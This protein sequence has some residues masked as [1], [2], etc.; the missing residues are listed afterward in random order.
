MSMSISIVTFATN[1]LPSASEIAN[2]WV[3]NGIIALDSNISDVLKR[4]DAASMYVGIVK[5]YRGRNAIEDILAQS[6]KDCSFVDITTTNANSKWIKESCQLGVFRWVD[7][8]FLDQNNLTPSQALVTLMRVLWGKQD[9]STTPW[10]KNYLDLATKHNIV[11]TTDLDMITNGSS[12][13]KSKIL[14]WIYTA[15]NSPTLKTDPLVKNAGVDMFG[16]ND[17]QGTT[18]DNTTVSTWWTTTVVENTR[19]IAK[20]TYKV[21]NN[22]QNDTINKDGDHRSMVRDGRDKDQDHLNK[23]WWWKWGLNIW[24]ILL[25]IIWLRLVWRALKWLYCSCNNSNSTCNLCCGIKDGSCNCKNTAS[26]TISTTTNETH[27]KTNEWVSMN[28]IETWW[29]TDKKEHVWK[30]AYQQHDDLKIIEGIWPK[31]EELLFENNITTF[32]QLA[33]MSAEEISS[34]LI[35]YWGNF[36]SMNT[37]TWS[38]QALLAK[39]GKRE[40]LEILKKILDNGKRPS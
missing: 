28:A 24:N 13:T 12:I 34:I 4:G 30:V 6:T 17:V 40:E 18:Q 39:E 20:D 37:D 9:E 22:S 29:F 1:P 3:K 33:E 11:P 25:W 38:E 19:S 21:S 5:Q 16:Q 31:V 2:R 8:N 32:T 26:S 23:K 14:E 36:A 27:H 15:T 35:P 7:G 10:R